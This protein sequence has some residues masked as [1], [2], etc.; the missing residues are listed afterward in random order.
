MD[1][2]EKELENIPGTTVE[3]TDDDMLLIRLDEAVAFERG[4]SNLTSSSRAAL[5]RAADVLNEYPKTAVVV[6]GHTAD[7]STEAANMEL[8]ERRAEMVR[9]YLIGEGIDAERLIAVGYGASEGRGDTVEIL[10]KA[11]T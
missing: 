1:R 9:S 11:K 5:D 10:L 3:R 6:Q 8:S 4:S 2:Q 7:R